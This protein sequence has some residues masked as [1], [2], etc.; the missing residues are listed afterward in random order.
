MESVGS[1]LISEIERVSALR[2][3]YRSLRSLRDLPPVNVEPV[4]LMMSRAILA[5]K[6]AVL[7]D[8]PA[9]AIRC[10]KELQGFT[11]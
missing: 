7:C 11:A 4:I 5:A 8:D 9:R 10:L 3:Q 1:E 2:E 6:D